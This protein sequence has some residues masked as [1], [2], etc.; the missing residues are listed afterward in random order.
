V[1]ILDVVLFPD[2]YRRSREAVHSSM[3]LL[4]TGTMEMDSSRAE[5]MLRAERVSVCC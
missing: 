4:V 1:G 5:P 3:P 2:A